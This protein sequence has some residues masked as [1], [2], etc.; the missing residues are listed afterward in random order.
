MFRNIFS[1]II[2][3]G[4]SITEIL[5]AI[6]LIKKWF[7]KIQFIPL[8]NLQDIFIY[9]PTEFFIILTFFYAISSF[10][11]GITTAL[12]VKIAKKAYAV[13]NGFILFIIAF[14]HIFLYTLP[15]WFKIIIFPIFFSFSYLGGE[16]IENFY[17]KKDFINK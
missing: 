8:K 6:E 15:L 12:F 1:V 4:V 17:K 11:G 14:I 16:F 3:I 13:L 2:G 9:A 7:V 5:S 10:I